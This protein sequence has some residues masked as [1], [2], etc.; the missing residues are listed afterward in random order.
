M[1]THSLPLPSPSPAASIAARHAIA[2]LRASRD[3]DTS[4]AY[5]IG[6]PIP[7]RVVLPPSQGELAC[8]AAHLRL[9]YHAA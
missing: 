1:N 9:A 7:V 8:N 6:Q 5:R 2:R 4:V 3:R